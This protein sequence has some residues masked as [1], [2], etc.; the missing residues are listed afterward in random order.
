MIIP[1]DTTWP[2]E[3]FTPSIFGFESRP[4]REEPSPFL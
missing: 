1:A 3:I 2:S 4:F